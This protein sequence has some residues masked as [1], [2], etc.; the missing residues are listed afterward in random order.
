MIP[1]LKHGKKKGDEGEVESNPWRTRYKTLTKYTND[2]LGSQS[3]LDHIIGS[4]VNYF[5][6]PRRQEPVISCQDACLRLKWGTGLEQI[7]HD[8]KNHCYISVPAQIT[9]AGLVEPRE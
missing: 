7:D 1:L 4:M 6:I 2:F 9:D 5:Q 8:K 3:K